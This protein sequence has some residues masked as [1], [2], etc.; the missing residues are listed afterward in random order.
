ML[1]DR[2]GSVMFTQQESEKKI[3]IIVTQQAGIK[4]EIYVKAS[5]G[6]TDDY[7]NFKIWSTAP[8]P[9]E[10][11]VD[12]TIAKLGSTQMTLSVKLGPETTEAST[13]AYVKMGNFV[14]A[15]SSLTPRSYNGTIFTLVYV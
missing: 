13:S 4:Q 12:F 9:T 11:K 6:S 2:T 5:K 14:Y 15:S 8:L 7:T 3:E 10:V 1:S